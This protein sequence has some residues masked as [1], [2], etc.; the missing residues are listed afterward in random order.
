MTNPTKKSRIS[1]YVLCALSF[2]CC[3]GPLM[4]YTAAALFSPAGLLISKVALVGAVLVVLILTM[5]ALVNKMVFRSRIFILLLGLY[6]CLESIIT[7]LLLVGI[8]QIVDELVVA[9]AKA[10]AKTRLIANKAY[11]KREAHTH[12]Q[13]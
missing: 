5:I 11:D 2:L 6:L 12:T 7:P 8:G 13:N 4:Y 9:P 10:N 3:F 1:Y